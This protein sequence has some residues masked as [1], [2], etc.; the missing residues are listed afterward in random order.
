MTANRAVLF[1]VDH[2]HRDLPSLS[3]IGFYLKQMGWE[4]HFVGMGDELDVIARVNP[5]AILLPKPVFD[6]QRLLRWRREGRHLIVLETEGNPQDQVFEMRILVAPDLYLF[7]NDAIADRYRPRLAPR[8]TDMK[9]V[10]FHRSDLLHPRLNAVFPTRSEL[11][12]RYQL[13]AARKTVTIAT[14]AQDSHFSEER[15]RQ[16]R[17]RRSRSLAKTADYLEIVANMRELRDRTME[18]VTTLSETRPDVNIALKPHPN[19]NVVFWSDFITRL[20]KPQVR[21][22]VGEPINHLL[23]VSDFHVA[24]NVCTTSVEALLAGVPAMELQT[25]RSLQLYGESHLDLP[26]YRTTTLEAALEAIDRETGAVPDQRHHQPDQQAKLDA[27]VREFLHVFDGRRCEAYAATLA[28][29]LASAPSRPVGWRAFLRHPSL[30]AL[31]LVVKANEFVSSGRR[32]E[33]SEVIRQ[34]NRPGA[35]NTRPVRQINGIALDEEFG[36]F[37][38]RMRLGDEG[39]WLSLFAKALGPT[40]GAE[41]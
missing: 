33:T 6:Y 19:E 25:A 15:M 27:Y 29:W 28:Q 26:N 36:L 11:L 1:L 41:V 39:V 16:K 7:W 40:P 2:K 22:V 4:P 32:A 24:F 30:A 12:A 37:D 17:K 35:N 14:S 20:A 21:L 3:L 23:R 34:V 38:N 13:D 8:G 31:A 5:V 9:V 18:L 10:G